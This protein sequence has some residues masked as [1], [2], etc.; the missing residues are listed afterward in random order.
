MSFTVAFKGKKNMSENFFMLVLSTSTVSVLFP[1][2]NI[3]FYKIL[4]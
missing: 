4:T 2:Y 1:G 3:R